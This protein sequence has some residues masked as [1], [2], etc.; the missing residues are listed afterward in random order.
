MSSFLLRTTFI[1]RFFFFV[2][3]CVL[4]QRREMREKFALFFFL[5]NEAN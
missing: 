4:K 2:N 5:I 3:A 1:T